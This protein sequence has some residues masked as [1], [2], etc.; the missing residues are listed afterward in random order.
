MYI[1]AS[2]NQHYFN[3]PPTKHSILHSSYKLTMSEF[4]PFFKP[5]SGPERPPTAY[6]AAGR[7]GSSTVLRDNFTIPTWLSFGAVVQMSLTYFLGS[8]RALWLPVAWL[9]I[10]FTSTF[11]QTVGLS[12]NKLLDASLIAKSSAQ[13]PDLQTGKY[14][15]NPAG[16]PITV[17]LV[18]ARSNH[19]LGLMAPGFREMGD[20][21]N[22]MC[23]DLSSS[24][25]A[26][27]YGLIGMSPWIGAQRASGNGPMMV[28]YFES[29]DGVHK[30]AHDPMHAEAWRWMSVHAK[31]YP[32]LGFWHES[33]TSEAGK[34]EA[35]YANDE[36]HSLGAG[37]VPVTIKDEESGK[38]EEMW[39]G[40]L[41]DAT[42]G[43]LKSSR[44][45]LRDYSGLGDN[46]AMTERV[47]A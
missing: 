23:Q 26:K 17:F 36:P 43:V 21:F 1:L 24:R 31:K 39:Y 34:W 18:G 12:R 13:L 22:S 3:I 29:E 15:P 27:E 41:V 19:P 5:T 7:L 9:L 47:Y 45:R 20:Y 46:V 8:K 38:T 4:I 28:M 14:G 25:G 37:A 2:I 11:L 42:K 30:F 6:T 44:G 35:I 32:H 16:R 10:K 33:F 40:T